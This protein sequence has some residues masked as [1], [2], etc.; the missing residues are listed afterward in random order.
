MDF[1]SGALAKSVGWN[2]L[3]PEAVESICMLYRITNDTMYQDWG[4]QIFQA[5]EKYSKVRICASQP[6][7]ACVIVAA[8]SM[9]NLHGHWEPDSRQHFTR[10]LQPCLQLS[11]ACH[12]RRDAS[13]YTRI[14][15]KACP[16]ALQLRFVSCRWLGE[17]IVD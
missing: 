5:F 10:Q 4:W 13:L 17:D 6:R 1:E 12:L 11:A 16:G 15:S 2:I 14:N 9:G 8:R 7:G 3:R